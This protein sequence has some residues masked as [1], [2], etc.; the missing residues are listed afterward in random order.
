VKSESSKA[1]KSNGRK[2][3]R[4]R[5]CWLSCWNQSLVGGTSGAEKAKNH[6]KRGTLSL[7]ISGWASPAHYFL[8][9]CTDY[10]T[11]VIWNRPIL[12]LQ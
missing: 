1:I 8:E 3:W 7:L 9:D 6:G 10:G 4:H 2:S 12:S 11:L 5:F